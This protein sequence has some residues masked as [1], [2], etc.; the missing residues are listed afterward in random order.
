MTSAGWNT[1]SAKGGS[2]Q[3]FVTVPASELVAL[4]DGISDEAGA[5]FFINP[6][7]V[8]GLLEASGAKAGDTVVIT[9]AGSTLS[10][11]LIAAA[12]KRGLKTIGVVRRADAVAELKSS[13]GV[14]EVVV[15]SGSEPLAEEVK[16]LTGGRG[17]HSVIDSIGGDISRELG[18]AVRDGGSVWLYGLM[19]GVTFIGDGLSLLFRDVA[20][21]G[22]WLVPWL[23]SKTPAERQAVYDETLKLMADGTLAP[24]V[25]EQF[26]AAEFAAAVAA[27]NAVGRIGKVLLKF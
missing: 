15:F 4:P 18:A 11:M 24:A 8:I 19:G 5:Q 7:T 13:T 2:W 23:A 25:G 17:A 16:R 9:A 26:A 20:Y 1:A 27:S 12:R 10:R 6:V 22:F 14:D 21:R 3:Q